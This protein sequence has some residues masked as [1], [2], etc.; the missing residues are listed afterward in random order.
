M[1]A[2]RSALIIANP[3]AGAGRGGR[4]LPEI[5]EAVRARFGPAEIRLSRAPGEVEALVREAAVAG[6]PTIVVVGGDGTVNEAVGGL[7]DAAAGRLADPAPELLFLPAGTGG[8]YARSTGIHGLDP[9]EAIAAA[10]SRRVDLGLAAVAGRDGRPVTRLFANILSAGSSA[11]I[12]ESVNRASKRLGG[13]LAF[14]WG[15]LKGLAVWRDRRL[16]VVADGEVVAEE[17]LSAVVVAV[18]RCFGGGIRIAPGALLDDGLFDVVLMRPVGPLRFVAKGRRAYRGTHLELPEFSLLRGR[19]VRVEAL[20]EGPPV[21]V[22]ADGE[23]PGFLPL[24]AEILPGALR[25]LAPWDRAPAI[26]WER[27]AG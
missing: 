17:L 4:G 26:T 10:T 16:R 22:E 9:A 13:R 12:A 23:H 15:T 1:T 25:L 5:E 21:P 6:V 24:E 3:K 2:D 18:G 20:D 11:H 27:S 19:R 8:D 7:W 14:A